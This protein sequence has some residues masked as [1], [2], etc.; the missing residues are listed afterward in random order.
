MVEIGGDVEEET[1]VIIELLAK[2]VAELD[3]LLLDA[4]IDLIGTF[5]VQFLVMQ[6]LMETILDKVK[7]VLMAIISMPILLIIKDMVR[8]TIKATLSPP[9]SIHKLITIRPL[10][11]LP[12]LKP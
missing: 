4:T 7:V 8:L 3:T 6:I 10:R 11:I 1:R 9:I 2:Y 12:L 5:K